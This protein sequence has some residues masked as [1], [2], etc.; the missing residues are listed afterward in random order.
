MLKNSSSFLRYC[1]MLCCTINKLIRQLGIRIWSNLIYSTVA[2]ACVRCNT[3]GYGHQ[4]LAGEGDVRGKAAE[5]LIS[6]SHFPR[7]VSS[8]IKHIYH[9]YS[10]FNEYESMTRLLVDSE[11]YYLYLRQFQ[12]VNSTTVACE[13]KPLP[14]ANNDEQIADYTTAII[15]PESL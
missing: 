1:R 7:C 5:C 3:S 10:H 12:S 14:T 4:H 15:S 8:S 9:L 6:V 11:P 2:F 13:Q